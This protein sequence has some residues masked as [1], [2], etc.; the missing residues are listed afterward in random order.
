MKDWWSR[1]IFGYLPT[2]ADLL[3]P[4]TE[5]YL[6]E[7]GLPEE[8]AYGVIAECLESIKE[9]DEIYNAIPVRI[10]ALKEE[11]A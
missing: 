5:S 8:L 1:K 9:D 11:T 4:G 3:M 6:H 10:K 7:A 2:Y